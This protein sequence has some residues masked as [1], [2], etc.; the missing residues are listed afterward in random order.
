MIG[1]GQAYFYVCAVLSMLGALGVVVAKNPIRGAM[2]LLLMILSIAGLFLALH[3][4]FLAA[5][6]LIVYAGAIVVLFLF[7]IMLLGPSASTPSDHRGRIP[8]MIGAA[9]FGAAGIGAI[10]LLI[11]FLIWLGWYMVD[12][13]YYD[14]WYNA[15]L[16]WHRVLGLLVLALALGKIGWQLYSPVPHLATLKPWERTAARGM[17][18]L[19]LLMMVTIPVTGYLISSSAG[20]SI[21]LFAGLEIPALFHVSEGLRDLA[22]E[23][24]GFP[25]VDTND[26]AA[27]LKRVDAET[28]D[29]Y[30]LGFYSSNPDPKKRTRT[31]EVKVDRPGVTVSA[32]RAYSLKTAGKPP[33]P[34]ASKP[35]K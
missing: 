32:R 33:A 30:V 29:Y 9:L 1:L 4:Q 3:A 12:L 19:L 25:I 27:G 28:S 34:P 2:G 26:F 35:K 7:V 11:I 21:P 16:H 22:E 8:R 14:K 31:L 13:T 15:S 10:A 6:Q 23:T 5:I 20:K 24:G 18:F 17:H